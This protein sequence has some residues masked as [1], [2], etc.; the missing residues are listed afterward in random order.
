V[1]GFLRLA[2]TALLGALL[3][4]S[5]QGQ[6]GLDAGR[7]S[8]SG[9][10]G[11]REPLPEASGAAS[12]SVEGRV[13]WLG[14]K[15]ALPPLVTSP[16]VQSVC[17]PSVT[18]NAFRTDAQGGVAEVVVWVDAPPAPSASPVHEVVLDQK[19]CL[20]RPPVL[21]ARA[22][23]T[24]R[25]RNSDP[26]THTVHARSGGQTAFNVAMPLQGMELTRRLP[27]EPGVVDVSCDVHPW[28][29][30]VVRTFNHPHFT[31]T[32]AEGRFRLPGL[33]PGE[34]TLHAWHPTLGE[35]SQRVRVAA[36][37]TRSDFNFGGKP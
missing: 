30:A 16:S 3:G 11:G 24:L 35:A 4:C 14:P 22:G 17:G 37:A 19:S 5:R 23:S 9:V 12:G 31:T 25:L 29:R 36:G 15:V 32:D 26:L 7:A 2:L 33:E 28:M 18:D 13:L 34:V 10:E 1:C 20:Y 8:L 21:A 6:T 27:G